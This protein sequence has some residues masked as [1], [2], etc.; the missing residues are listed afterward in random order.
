M[1]YLGHN[2]IEIDACFDSKFIRQGIVW[3]MMN[4]LEENASLFYAHN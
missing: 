4:G 1:I 2:V 3:L